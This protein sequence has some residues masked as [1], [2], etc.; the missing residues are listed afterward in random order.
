MDTKKLTFELNTVMNPDYASLALMGYSTTNC[1][2]K[3]EVVVDGDDT[4]DTIYGSINAYSKGPDGVEPVSI[5]VV[6]YE[7]PTGNYFYAMLEFEPT[8]C[9]R[10]EIS[11]P[12]GWET[13][14]Y[15]GPFRTIKA[16]V[17][18]FKQCKDKM[19][20]ETMM[21]AESERDCPPEPDVLDMILS[22]MPEWDNEFFPEELALLDLQEME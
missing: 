4:E 9:H 5:A 19:D 13:G 1:F 21:E 14:E 22:E 17:A 3:W 18:D 16:M 11:D 2:P 6:E 10:G 12:G 8:I 20:K 15:H 7:I